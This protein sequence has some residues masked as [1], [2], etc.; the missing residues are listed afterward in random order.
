MQ[1][2]WIAKDRCHNVYL[3]CKFDLVAFDK[4]FN[5]IFVWQVLRIVCWRKTPK[6]C[7]TANSLSHWAE[8]EIF[9]HYKLK[10]FQQQ[11]TCFEWNVRKALLQRLFVLLLLLCAVLARAADLCAANVDIWESSAVCENAH[12]LPTKS[13]SYIY[14][15]SYS[16]IAML[17]K[18]NTK[19]ILYIFHFH[20]FLYVCALWMPQAAGW[21]LNAESWIRN[22]KATAAAVC[23]SKGNS[24]SFLMRKVR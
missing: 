12:R 15:S 8:L 10:N 24:K 22:G 2:H 18:N 3:L 13:L 14:R 5:C 19:Y 6:L 9:L 1:V 17:E 7:A 4:Q 21:M 23:C 11:T 16:C 20:F